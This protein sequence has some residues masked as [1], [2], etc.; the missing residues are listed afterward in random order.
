MQLKKKLN[1][2]S[3]I[4]KIKNL[5]YLHNIFKQSFK[6]KQT[7]FHFHMPFPKKLSQIIHFYK[8]NYVNLIETNLRFLQTFL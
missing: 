8:Y 2:K 1:T 5:P 6:P 3:Q 4:I 7:S